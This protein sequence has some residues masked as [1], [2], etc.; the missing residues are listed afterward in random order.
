LP[1]APKGRAGRVDALIVPVDRGLDAVDAVLHRAWWAFPGAMVAAFAFT[2][3][4]HPPD[5]YGG[6]GV[7]VLVAL[8]AV[9]LAARHPAAGWGLRL[10]LPA[11]ALVGL[12]AWSY[13][14][15][16]WSHA[17]GRAAL[18]ASRTLLYAAVLLAAAAR[19]WTAARVRGLALALLAA[20]CAAAA[21]GVA[22]HLLPDLTGIRSEQHPDRLGWPV[23]Y[24]NA[25]GLLAGMGAILAVN[26][27]A[28]A[29]ERLWVRCA[30][31][32]ATPLLVSTLL[33]TLSRGALWSSAAGLAVWLVLAR[34]RGLPA[35]AL[36]VAPATA[37]ALLA[38]DRGGVVGTAPADIARAGL[39][40]TPAA[41]LAVAV[42][43]AAILRLLGGPLDRRLAA[44]RLGRR[45]RRVLAAGGAVVLVAAVGAGAL[46]AQRSEIPVR[47]YESFVA[48]GESDQGSASRLTD[49]SNNNRLSKWTIARD[50]FD[51]DPLHGLGAGTYDLAWERARPTSGHVLDAHSLYLQTLA[52]LGWPGLTLLLVA[53]GGVLAGL[54]LRARGPARAV[55][56]ALLGTVVAWSLSA[57]VDWDWQLPVVTAWIFAAGGL[58]LARDAAAPPLVRG[59]GRLP[60][61]LAVVLACAIAAIL[62]LRVALSQRHLDRGV[63]A[64]QAGDC[65]AAVA[66]GRRAHA[67]LA[68][69][70][71]PLQLIGACELASR[72]WNAAERTWREVA[73]ADPGSW[74]GPYGIALARAGAG[75]PARAALA[76]ALA[77]NPRERILTD[78]VDALRRPGRAARRAALSAPVPLP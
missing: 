64:A 77:R 11:T 27:A 50:A 34:P 59:R 23:S 62:P 10:A 39:G 37:L 32:A 29:G 8:A 17:P 22:S 2:A 28:A 25:L 5:A 44:I 26:F 7:V 48:T 16:E 67:A 61:R 58:A 30:G 54:G 71:G 78:R 12:T 75:R 55:P 42:A 66:E 65:A 40:G 74:L 63:A 20:S 18:E 76:A 46:A 72:R 57:A 73:A 13:A 70:A 52:E 31:A 19:G 9:V 47:A 60:V 69:R 36:A 45:G 6:G 43:A 15:S 3:G 49:L 41:L 33:L 38:L 68:S 24:W 53:L 14:S 51:A 56:A 35:A 21:A 4:G 1:G